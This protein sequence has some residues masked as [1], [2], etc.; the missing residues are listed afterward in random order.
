VAT[1]APARG[2]RN[3]DDVYRETLKPLDRIAINVAAAVGSWKFIIWQSV[4]FAVWIVLTS[5]AGLG[6][7]IHIRSS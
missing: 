5:S 2:V 1:A 3:V 7:G 6:A 4:F